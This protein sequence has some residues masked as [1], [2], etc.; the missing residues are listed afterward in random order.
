MEELYGSYLA[1][2]GIL[3]QKWGVRRYQNADGSLTE[4]GR[5]RYGKIEK[6]AVNAANYAG[7]QQY[8]TNKKAELLEQ[9]GSQYRQK[10]SESEAEMKR[11]KEVKDRKAYKSAKLDYEISKDTAEH[12]GKLA[13][14]ARKEGEGW[15]N[16]YLKYSN[17]PATELTKKDIKRGK[18]YVK[19]WLKS[20]EGKFYQDLQKG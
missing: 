4:A 3:G 16:E 8:K 1:H 5:K 18:K 11:A 10:T 2:H 12:I 15:V 13:S 7:L 19:Q 6:M 14:K 17:T 9:L 20:P